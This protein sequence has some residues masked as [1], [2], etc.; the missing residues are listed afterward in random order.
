MNVIIF[1][2][3]RIM[4]IFSELHGQ[5][6]HIFLIKLNLRCSLE[7]AAICGCDLRE[8]F[9][10]IP[11]SLTPGHGIKEGANGEGSFPPSQ[12]IRTEGAQWPTP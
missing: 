9:M 10:G 1:L 12:T 6:L 3:T 11:G 7:T 8:N 4:F 2:Q 5:K